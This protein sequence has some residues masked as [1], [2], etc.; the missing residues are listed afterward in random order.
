[1]PFYDSTAAQVP[2][3]AEKREGLR[4]GTIALEITA[5]GSM[6]ML[7]RPSVY[8]R[9]TSWLYIFVA[10]SSGTKPSGS[11]GVTKELPGTCVHVPNFVGMTLS[12]L[13]ATAVRA[14]N[15]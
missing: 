11:A 14:I 5:P 13:G 8:V 2:G 15:S 3:K 7:P 12:S 1:M 6:T 10:F 9:A 4:E